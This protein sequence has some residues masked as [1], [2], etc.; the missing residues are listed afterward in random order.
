MENIKKDYDK[1]KDIIMSCNNI[2][3]LKVAN[4][5]LDKL[6]DKH[7]NNLTDKQINI[8]KL[9]M[10]KLNIQDREISNFQDLYFN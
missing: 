9:I 3:Q 1:V 7:K 8:L 5:V 4:K 6:V 10:N 2:S